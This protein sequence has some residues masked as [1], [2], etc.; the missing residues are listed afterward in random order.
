MAWHDDTGTIQISYR[1]VHLETLT[2]H[3]ETIEPIVRAYCDIFLTLNFVYQ[4]TP[5]SK[6]ATRIPVAVFM[7][8]YDT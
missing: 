5:G 7:G 2:D 8:Q 3:V 1:P 6:E 4:K